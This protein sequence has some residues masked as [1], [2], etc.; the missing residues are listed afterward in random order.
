MKLLLRAL[1]LMPLADGV[2]AI[3]LEAV[4]QRTVEHNLQ[5][6]SAQADLEGAYGRRLVLRSVGLPNL[7]LGVAGGLQGGHRSGEKPVQPFG[8]AYE[9]FIQPIFN[10]VV[11]PSQRRGDIEV[12]IAEQQ[13]NVAVTNQ[14]HTARV[15]FYTAIY[16]RDLKDVRQQ[17][18]E[19]LQQNAANQENRYQSGV[20]DHGSFV[21]A[22]VQAGELVP[23]IEAAERAYAGAVLQLSEA[24]GENFVHSAARLGPEGTLHYV[25][26]DVPLLKATALAL[27]RP[28]LQLARLLVR[29]ARQDERI[30]AAAYYPVINA[31]ISGEYIPVTGVRRLQSQGSPRRSDDIISSEIR[32]GAAYTW[33]VIDNG[34]I[35]GAVAQQRAMVETN[36][37]L[38]EKMERDVPLDLQRIQNNLDAIATKRKA[39][40][41]ATSAAEQNVMTVRQNIDSGIGS[42]LEY[43]LAENDLLEVQSSLLTLVYLQNVALAEWDRATGRYLRL[44]TYR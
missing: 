29:S 37:L 23:K 17:Q 33:Q 16:N 5:I 12:L 31:V 35:S 4:L 3:T 21:A 2:N 9:N 7:L 38:L 40:E 19:R 26:F 32:A 27:N 18:L 8:F 30:I 1:L 39:L 14:L 28:D 44:S 43:R 20:T 41:S 24:M 25:N 36:Q 6:R 11:P 10:M 34:K 42:Q 13:L 22:E 15:A